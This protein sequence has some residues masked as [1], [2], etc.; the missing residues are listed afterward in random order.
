MKKNSIKNLSYDEIIMIKEV[1]KRGVK[2][3]ME[4]DYYKVMV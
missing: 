1:D 4:E 2:V 3:I